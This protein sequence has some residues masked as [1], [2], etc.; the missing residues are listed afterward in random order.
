MASGATRSHWWPA[1]VGLGSNLQGPAAQL[2][3][4]FDRLSGISKTRLVS[5]SSLYR[6]APLGGIEQPDFVNAVA[7]LLTRLSARQLLTE[8]QQIEN[9]HGRERNDV[10]W[11][12]RVLDLD[13]LVYSDKTINEPDLTVPHSGIAERNFVLLPL[14]EVAPALN[15]AGLGRIDTIP[16]N[17]DEPKISRIA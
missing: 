12:P 16:V 4:A 1:Y 2:D 8:L 5:R 7:A 17:L 9:Q 6:S 11:G 15:I 14:R 13:L 10:R 3:C